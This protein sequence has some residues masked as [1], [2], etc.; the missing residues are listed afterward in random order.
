MGCFKTEQSHVGEESIGPADVTLSTATL[1]STAATLEQDGTQA[2]A[3][4]AVDVAEDVRIAAVL[5]VGVPTPEGP[6]HL[7]HDAEHGLARGPFR[8]GAQRVFQFLH[9]LATRPAFAAAKL[10]AQK[11]KA[12][13]RK[14]VV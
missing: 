11:R 6:V 4:P 12:L 13:D 8:L 5:E 9:A 10:V 14:S 1:P 2:S 7:P 3:E